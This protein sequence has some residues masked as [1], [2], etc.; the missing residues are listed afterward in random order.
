MG[1]PS[2]SVVIPTYQRKQAVCGAVLSI[3]KTDYDGSVEIVVVVDG[4]T[5]G[6]AS[7]LKTLQCRFPLRIV[8]QAN[9]GQASA[10][11]RGAAEARGEILL[12]LDDDMLAE[13]SLLS[14]H[15]RLHSDGA[16]AVTGEIPLSPHSRPNLVTDA[17]ARAAAW[18]RKPPLTGFDIYSGHFSVAKRVF[19]KIGGFDEKMLTDGYGTEDLD[20]GLR[21]VPGHDVRHSKAAVAWQQSSIGPGEHM[22]RARKLAKSDA[23]AIQKHPEA[24]ST[25]L[26]ARELPGSGERALA[27]RLSRLPVVPEIASPV[28][29]SLAGLASKAGFGSNAAI[30][31][32]Y[33][34][35]WA[36]AY[37]SALRK[38]AGAA[39][40][41]DWVDH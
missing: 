35:A 39:T 20:F 29:V 37:W 25:L 23:R 28:A 6:T 38:A 24:L 40:F 17:L 41:D 1:Q 21:L 13:P 15:A 34:A 31:R 3:C 7:A 4:S 18:E 16:D 26:E 9:R 30:A 22:K 33:F 27:F 12:F 36:M 8:E 14:E 10:R 5:D 32:L 11:N 2:F 19:D